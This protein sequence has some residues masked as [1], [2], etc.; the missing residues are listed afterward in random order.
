MHP[1]L[2]PSSPVRLSLSSYGNPQK[3]ILGRLGGMGGGGL[4]FLKKNSWPAHNRQA[5]HLRGWLRGHFTHS[6]CTRVR[7]G[8]STARLQPVGPYCPSGV[9]GSYFLPLQYITC[10]I[11]HVKGKNVK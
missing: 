4:K 1:P 3:Q 10:Q 9:R 5:N 7:D 2:L 8:L 11:F 6:H